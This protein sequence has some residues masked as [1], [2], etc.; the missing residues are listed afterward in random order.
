MTMTT[1]MMMWP[2]GGNGFG[3]GDRKGRWRLTACVDKDG[4]EEK[5]LPRGEEAFKLLY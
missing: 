4:A 1:T 5:K 3:K 2:L